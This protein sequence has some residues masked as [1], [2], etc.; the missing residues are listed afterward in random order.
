M[1]LME[2]I[3]KAAAGEALS[4][5]ER[6][7]LAGFRP[8]DEGSAELGKRNRELEARL[9]ELEKSALTEPEQLRRRYDAELAR[10][11]ESLQCTGAE[12]DAAKQ[13]LA[14]IGFR[15]RIDRLAQEQGFS[16]ADY[17][18]YL[19]SRNRID[20]ESA[21]AV[22]PFM[23]GLRESSPRLF[24]LDLA[25]GAPEPPP[26][27]PPARSG[28]ASDDLVSLLADAPTVND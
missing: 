12:R 15:S 16:D 11:R 23:K 17:L 10:L 25:P 13:E 9:E 14:R 2:I 22:E 19:C 5:E 20:P 24:R 28:R 6:S 4:G 3:R 26:G 21:E 27:P 7:M 1:D 8:G 18:E